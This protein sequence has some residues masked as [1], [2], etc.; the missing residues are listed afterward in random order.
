MP[1]RF[2]FD[3]VFTVFMEM[4]FQNI[5]S[6]IMIDAFSE[7]KEEDNTRDEDKKNFCYICGMSK[8]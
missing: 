4:L 6:G 7:L 3:I 2:S 8:P 1:W 5:V